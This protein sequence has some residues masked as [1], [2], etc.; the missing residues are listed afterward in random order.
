M[1]NK[2]LVKIEEILVFINLIEILHFLPTL[3]AFRLPRP[4]SLTGF[5]GN[6][7]LAWAYTFKA[8]LGVLF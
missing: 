7:H 4:Y 3:Y 1:K 5:S 8:R 2:A 6:L